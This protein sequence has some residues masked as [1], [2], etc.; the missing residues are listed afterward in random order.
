MNETPTPLRK[1]DPPSLHPRLFSA[2]TQPLTPLITGVP[3]PRAAARCAASHALSAVAGVTCESNA[4]GAGSSEVSL[5]NQMRK[6][7]VAR[8]W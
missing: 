6:A 7:L 5:A 3:D 8:K 1:N 2:K 4:E